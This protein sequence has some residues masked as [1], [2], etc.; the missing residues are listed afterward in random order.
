MPRV[1]LPSVRLPSIRLPSIRIPRIQR[2]ESGKREQERVGELRRI[3]Q[4]EH[5]DKGGDSGKFQRAKREF[6]RIRRKRKF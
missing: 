1:R 2:S 3:I 5:P 6:D 4:R